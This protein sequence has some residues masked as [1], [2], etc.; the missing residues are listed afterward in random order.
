M[1][2]SSNFVKR[3][4]FWK[5]TCNLLPLCLFKKD[6]KKHT[7]EGLSIKE[8]KGRAPNPNLGGG[9]LARGVLSGGI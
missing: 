4:Q 2:A 3:F 9:E 6:H 7:G 8:K 5:K 1:G